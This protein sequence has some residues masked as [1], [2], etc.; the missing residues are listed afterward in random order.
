MISRAR[1]ELFR[2]N[3]AEKPF[4][5]LAQVEWSANTYGLNLDIISRSMWFVANNK[6]W[7][8]WAEFIES[9]NTSVIR[10]T[11]SPGWRIKS[12]NGSRA[13]T[14]S[15]IYMIDLQTMVR[16][17][18]YSPRKTLRIIKEICTPSLR[19]FLRAYKNGHHHT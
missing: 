14:S 7:R 15:E 18:S 10:E 19:I 13:T 9:V 11:F 12:G 6:Q 16:P 5:F 3:G 17:L 2:L 8:T 4:E 1:S